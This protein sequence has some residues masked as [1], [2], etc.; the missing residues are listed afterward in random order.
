MNRALLLTVA[1]LLST[2]QLYAKDTAGWFYA[3]SHKGSA[4]DINGGRHDAKEYKGA[5]P[6]LSDRISGPTPEYPRSERAMHHQGR[7]IVGL[8][9]D[10]KTGRVIKTSLLSS[11]GYA[12]LD[13]CAIAAFSRWT[14]RPGRWKEVDLTVGFYINN[15]YFR[16]PVSGGTRLPQS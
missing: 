7:A 6:W 16:P 10:V 13:R 5:P 4:V 8:I 11:S 14:W 2:A 9:L 15:N 12:E 1:G 3:Q